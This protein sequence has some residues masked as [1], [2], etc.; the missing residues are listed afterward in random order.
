MRSVSVSLDCDEEYIG[1]HILDSSPLLSVSEW[2]RR[3]CV[4]AKY[5]TGTEAKGLILFNRFIAV[6][7]ADAATGKFT[8]DNKMLKSST[9]LRQIAAG[10]L[11]IG[12]KLNDE[13]RTTDALAKCC[14]EQLYRDVRPNLT[15][16]DDTSSA[17]PLSRIEEI[18]E[19][20]CPRHRVP[21]TVQQKRDLEVIFTEKLRTWTDAIFA[22]E[23]MV[24]VR[25]GFFVSACFLE[26]PHVYIPVVANLLSQQ[27]SNII[28][29]A[30]HREAR[31]AEQGGSEEKDNALH[32]FRRR[33]FFL[34]SIVLGLPLQDVY[35]SAKDLAMAVA[36]LTAKEMTQEDSAYTS[37][38]AAALVLANNNAKI[39]HTTTLVEHH[40]YSERAVPKHEKTLDGNLASR[41]GEPWPVNKLYPV[42]ERAG[43]S[44][45]G[46][47]G[48]PRKS[49]WGDDKKPFV[50]SPRP[51]SGEDRPLRNELYWGTDGPGRAHDDDW[52]DYDGRKRLH[53]SGHGG[54]SKRAHS[55]NPGERW[56][57]KRYRH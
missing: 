3:V 53:E 32:T 1:R 48:S 17:I 57:D 33:A 29:R 13:R 10:C 47:R 46:G 36:V 16:T 30:A 52:R 8:G 25:F 7:T 15:H 9:S 38:Y 5:S 2:L 21:L 28:R 42:S 12:A 56:M 11:F 44:R 50:Q 45:D 37:L 23:L 41:R 24:L 40:L 31:K 35:V 26:T 39:A 54:R 19:R 20:T 43:S 51:G 4:L 49:H 34:S 6:S 18:Y 22:Y 55:Q 14:L 27:A